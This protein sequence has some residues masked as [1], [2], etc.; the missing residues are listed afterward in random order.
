MTTN[1]AHLGGHTMRLFVLGATGRTGVELLDLALARGHAVTAFVRSP[2]KIIRRDERLAVIEGRVDEVGPMAAAMKGHDAV[3]SVLGPT[4]WQAIGGGT[5][6][7]RDST[8]RAL[9]AMEQAG[10]K[11]FLVVSSAL[12]FPG[13]GP[14]VAF[15]RSF[16][17]HH[18]R[19]L[20]AM[21]L[22]IEKSAV[23]WTVAR[24]PRLVMTRDEAFAAAEG[25]FPGR[26]TVGISMS[27][28]AVAVYLVDALERHLHS[29]RVIGLSR[30]LVPTAS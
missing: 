29:Q 30:A 8:T 25:S 18:I 6:L 2:R 27:W 19:D 9:S 3:V 5:T 11:R 17:G 10:V 26:L 12:L 22:A 24:P 28:R 20:R 21:E 1:T 23:E 7:M 4:P 13:G 16:I 14:G 15:F